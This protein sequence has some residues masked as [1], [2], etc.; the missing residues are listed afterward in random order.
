[1]QRLK[2]PHKA[3]V[4][5]GSNGGPTAWATG[6]VFGFQGGPSDVALIRGLRM[7]RMSADHLAGL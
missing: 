6:I 2:V 1:M 4:S 5:N 3:R 7:Q